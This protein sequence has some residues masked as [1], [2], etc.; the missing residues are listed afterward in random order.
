MSF[1]NWDIKKVARADDWALFLDRDGVINRRLVGNYVK[2]WDEF[3]FLPGV[4]E[5]IALFARK[6]RHIFIITNQQGIGK[7]LMTEDDLARIHQKMQKEIEKAGGRIDAIYFCPSLAAAKSPRRK[8]APG[9]ALEAKKDFPDVDFSKSVMAGDSVSDMEFARNAGM[10]ALFIGSR[11]QYPDAD[12]Y[13][14]SL[15]EF[16]EALK[17]A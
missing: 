6:F 1:K 7:G 2:S 14:A 17:N 16:A 5:A 15:K 8:P 3:E 13:Y 11:E 9:M 4:L 10:Y 12:D